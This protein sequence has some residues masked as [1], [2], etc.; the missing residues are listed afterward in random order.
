MTSSLSQFHQLPLVEKIKTVASFSSLDKKD[1][2]LIDQYQKLPDFVD[3]ENNF[4][5]FKIASNFLINNK[6]YFVPMEIEEPSVVAAAS[7][8][9]KLVREGGGFFGKYL[10]N[11][12]IG[13]LQLIGIKNFERA[14]RE[15][16][17]NKKEILKKAN[18]TNKFLLSI[19]G[20]AKDFE[21]KKIKNFLVLYL[22][23][24]TK[25]AM[26][27]NLVNTML[28]EIALFVVKIVKTEIGLRIISNFAERRTVSIK[29]K[30][31]IEKLAL[32]EFSGAKVAQRILY[33][34]KLAENDIY[35]AVTHNKGV[36][37]GIDAVALATGN[38]FRAIESGVHSFAAKDGKYKPVTKWG[39][40][41]KFLKGEIKIPLAIATVGGATA[42]KKSRLALKILGV[43]NAQELGIVAASVGLAN[44]L[45]ALS[46]LGTEGIQKGHMKLHQEFL[47]K[48]AKK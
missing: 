20:G 18:E 6:D 38:D 30:V 5:P 36:M 19:S 29:G 7:R 32:D 46:V 21:I 2:K 41:K 43:K 48:T 16:F 28:E 13:Q 45:A 10:G 24:D 15:I 44:N 4:G 31:P 40:E 3:L 23:V 12:M 42:T 26:G 1:L 9:A 33:G 17:K 37:N 39:L 22:F 34:Q 8:A 14:K 11:Q 27:A 35:R 47:K 25:D